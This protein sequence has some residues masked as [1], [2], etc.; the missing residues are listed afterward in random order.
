MTDSSPRNKQRPKMSN[1]PAQKIYLLCGSSPKE[2]FCATTR[3]RLLR[4]AVET[5]IHQKR[6]VY[7]GDPTK[8]TSVPDQIRSL[9]ADAKTLT[10]DELGDNILGGSIQ[11]VANGQVI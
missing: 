7:Y 1:E 5:C 4:E 8:T 3:A 9:R 10:A 2:V 11:V 6:I